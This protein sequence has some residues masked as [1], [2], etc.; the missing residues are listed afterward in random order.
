MKK[1]KKSKESKKSQNWNGVDGLELNT[2]GSIPRLLSLLLD[3]SQKN[4]SMDTKAPINS[5]FINSMSAIN[6]WHIA[7]AV[8]ANGSDC[9]TLNNIGHLRAF[10][11]FL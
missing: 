7:Y 6:M 1:P 10:I 3:T 2:F 4:I 11:T 5:H 9:F 8:N